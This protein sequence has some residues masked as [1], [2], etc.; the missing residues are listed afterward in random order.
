[1]AELK[2]LYGQEGKVPENRRTEDEREVKEEAGEAKDDRLFQSC[3]LIL[4][5][6]VS[7]A[8]PNRVGGNIEGK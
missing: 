7:I 6:R 1:M 2:N 5:V 8:L 4:W 3:L